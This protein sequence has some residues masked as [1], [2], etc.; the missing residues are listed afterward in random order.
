MATG[1]TPFS[2][3]LN[4]DHDHRDVFFDAPLDE[5]S[6]ED[7]PAN[8]TLYDHTNSHYASVA[9]PKAIGKPRLGMLSPAQVDVIRRQVKGAKDRGLEARYWDTPAWPVGLREHV[10][11]VLVNEGVGMLNVDDLE[12]ASQQDWGKQREFRG[13]IE[14]ASD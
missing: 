10:W 2:S 14:E 12:A 8:G 3:I 6:G 9:F 11:D 13:M 4:L 5:L 7:A 1:N